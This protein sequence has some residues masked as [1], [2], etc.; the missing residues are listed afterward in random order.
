[1]PQAAG[2]ANTDVSDEQ[3][4]APYATLHLQDWIR[5][6]ISNNHIKSLMPLLRPLLPN[7]SGMESQRFGGLSRPSYQVQGN[8]SS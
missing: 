6:R 4:T 7:T 2:E 3:S 8:G 1:M 5:P